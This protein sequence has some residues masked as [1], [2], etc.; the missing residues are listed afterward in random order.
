[1]GNANAKVYNDT[2]K[3]VTI[4]VFNYA[5][6]L[7]IIERSKHHIEPGHT[8]DVEAAAHGSGLIVATGRKKEG[9][10]MSVGNG[11]T[12]NISSLLK[13][14]DSNPWFTPAAVAAGAGMA[15]AGAA[16]GGAAAVAA[17]ATSATI[18]SAAGVGAAIG[19]AG[20]GKI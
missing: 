1:M 8:V 18:G 14:G 12:L 9:N 19:S 4:F 11:K 7:R 13:D 5:D 6:A 15:A 16:T 3:E 2:D 17:G 10:H 20:A